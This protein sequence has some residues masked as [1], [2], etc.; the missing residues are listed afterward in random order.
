MPNSVVAGKL[1][2]V[3]V[4]LITLGRDLRIIVPPEMVTDIPLGT[5]LTVVVHQEPNGWLLAESV[6]IK[7]DRE[8]RSRRN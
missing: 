8:P 4:G 6:R 7:T 2:A 1:R 5:S 3:E